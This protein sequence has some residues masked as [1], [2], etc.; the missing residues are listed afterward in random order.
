MISLRNR[1]LEKAGLL[2]S[3]AQ[4]KFQVLLDAPV[5]RQTHYEL[6]ERI[7]ETLFAR[8]RAQVVRF[9]WAVLSQVA[10]EP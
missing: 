10:E 9:E 1:M 6:R 3:D 2:Q 5:Q 7:R 8:I 4:G